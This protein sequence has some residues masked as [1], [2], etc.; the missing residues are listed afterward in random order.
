MI[1]AKTSLNQNKAGLFCITVLA[2]MQIECKLNLLIYFVSDW[3][4][5][6]DWDERNYAVTSSNK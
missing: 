4:V 1:Q 6:R 5:G 2:A 3:Y